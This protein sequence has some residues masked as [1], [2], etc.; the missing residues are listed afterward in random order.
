MTV[1]ENIQTITNKLKQVIHIKKI[2][3]NSNSSFVITKHSK[4]FIKS[5]QG[6]NEIAVKTLQ[7][8]IDI[9]FNR[10]II[11][12]SNSRTPPPP[13]KPRKKHYFSMT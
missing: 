13:K 6:L 10:K 4:F 11:F 12:S 7:T 8:K 3:K 2:K 5:T 9:F 1:G